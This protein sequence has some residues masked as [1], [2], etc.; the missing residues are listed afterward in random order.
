VLVVGIYWVA[1]DGSRGEP[2]VF[3]NVTARD[4]RIAHIQDYRWKE[5][6]LK[7]ASAV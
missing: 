3:E 6:A 1:E 5:Q 4:G 7:A 2:L